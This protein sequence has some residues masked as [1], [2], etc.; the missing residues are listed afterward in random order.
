MKNPMINNLSILDSHAHDNYDEALVHQMGLQTDRNTRDKLE[1]NNAVKEL[2]DQRPAKSQL[3]VTDFC[4]PI[5]SSSTAHDIPMVH[6]LSHYVL[7][8]PPNTLVH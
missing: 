4:P 5:T 6:D 7:L 8:C 2:S 1:Y 3:H